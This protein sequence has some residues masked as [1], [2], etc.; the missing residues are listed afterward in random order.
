M[1]LYT[2]ITHC[3]QMGYVYAG[4]TNA[5][6][7]LCMDSFS[8][9]LNKTSNDCKCMCLNSNDLC[10]CKNTTRIHQALSIFIYKNKHFTLNY[11]FAD[12]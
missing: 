12:F 6:I 8:D 2:C 9:N 3:T 7:C 1:D 4:T 10:G 11:K 5:S